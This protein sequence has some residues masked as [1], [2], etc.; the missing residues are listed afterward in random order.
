[1][2][3]NTVCYTFSPSVGMRE[4]EDTLILAV[5]AVESL[6]GEFKV[7]LEAS[8]WVNALL[9]TCAVDAGNEVG[10]AICRV[11]TGYISL[12]FGEKAFEIHRVNTPA[13]TAVNSCSTAF[14][15]H[16]SAAQNTTSSSR[17]KMR[18]QT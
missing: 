13:S 7:R 2:K 3:K 18:A 10:R 8:Y 6:F 14:G 17:R 1:M 9:R 5:L 12:E 15:G 4:A 16:R 11:F